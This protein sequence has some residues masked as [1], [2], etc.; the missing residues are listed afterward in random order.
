MQ[1]H[2]VKMQGLGNDFVV[3]DLRARELP[4]EPARLARLADRRY[5]VGCDQILVLDAPTLADA[6]VR[7]RV[8]N[9]DGTR[10]EH[11]GNGVRCVARYLQ[12]RGEADTGALNVQIGERSYRLD[13][14]GDGEVRVEMGVPV[15]TPAHIPLAGE[16]EAAHYELK[17]EDR[18]FVFGAVSMGNPHAVF[19][20][21]DIETAPVA[22][23][24]A[25]LQAHPLFPARVNAGFLQITDA[26]HARLR[27]FERGA[28]ETPA[29]GTGACAAV[30]VGRLWG[31]LEPEVLVTLRGGQLRI[32]WAGPGSILYMTGPAEEVFEGNIAL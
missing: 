8:F 9:A 27:V 4:L 24:G 29:C 3:L 25:F 21:D 5:G 6:A 18:T 10:A 22:S 28:G 13:L 12:L 31:L 15:F 2:F 20:V 11:C 32:E 16:N 17:F 26:R 1:C 7:Y 30:A 14:L 23:L 19:R